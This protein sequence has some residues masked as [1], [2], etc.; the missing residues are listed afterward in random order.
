MYVRRR[1]T[2]DPQLLRQSGMPNAA[3]FL[4]NPP[5]SDP[6]HGS[7]ILSGVYLTLI[8]PIGRFLLAEAI[9]EAHTKTDGSPRILAHLGNVVRD[10]FGSSGSPSPSATHGSSAGAARRPGSS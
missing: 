7:G 9:R 2:F 4:V 5:I 8:S 1:F 3:I 10:L 6:S